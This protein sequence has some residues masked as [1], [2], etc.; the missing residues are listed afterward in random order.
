MNS[1]L[2]LL[3]LK[4]E[5]CAVSAQFFRVTSK[6][7]TGK[8]V[9][10]DH[11]ALCIYYSNL[12]AELDRFAAG[13]NPLPLLSQQSLSYLDGF[14]D[15]AS[16]VVIGYEA[17]FQSL[18]TELSDNLTG[19][20]STIN[21]DVVKSVVVLIVGQYSA[22]FKSQVGCFYL[23]EDAVIPNL[24][25]KDS[26]CLKGVP[27]TALPVEHNVGIARC[28][29]RKARTAKLSTLGDLQVVSNSDWLSDMKILTPAQWKAVLKFCR[30]SKQ[31]AMFDLLH[32]KEK[33]FLDKL[34]KASLDR[35]KDKAVEKARKKLGL[36]ESLKRHNGP[37]TSI[38]QLKKACQEANDEK[39]LVKILQSEVVYHRDVVCN[40]SADKRLYRQ[41]YMIPGSKAPIKY[42]ILTSNEL[43]ENLEK[44]LTLSTDLPAGMTAMES[45]EFIAGLNVIQ[46][47]L[48]M[49]ANSLKVMKGLHEDNLI[50]YAFN[51]G[52]FVASFFIED[53]GQHQICIGRVEYLIPCSQCEEC[54]ERGLTE[55][56]DRTPCLMVQYF[57]EAENYSHMSFT[58][59]DAQHTLVA[60]VICPVGVTPI[61]EGNET[62]YRVDTPQSEIKRLLELNTVYRGVVGNR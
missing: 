24:L 18:F 37:F 12:T 28:D 27:T 23:D 8:F 43:Q 53:D 21:L 11:A 20:V 47:K 19:E 50:N 48:N 55:L 22:V 62:S 10:P 39:S 3:I 7:T 58:E 14:P 17:V 13:A 5:L 16:S 26:E 15:L 9:Q 34:A 31:A 52:D 45:S 42:H 57:I 59:E 41:K 56:S 29:G 38:D 36:A 40:L 33:M 51:I 25:K 61:R 6:F 4:Q 49:Q 1:V 44:L 54:E 60:Q 46:N 30:K 32:Q 2:E 35:S